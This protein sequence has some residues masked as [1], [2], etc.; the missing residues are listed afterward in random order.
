MS[1]EPTD[2]NTVLPLP[3]VIHLLRWL[4][5]EEFVIL[6]IS[7]CYGSV[8]KWRLLWLPSAIAPPYCSWLLLQVWFIHSVLLL[9]QTFFNCILCDSVYL[10]V[11]VFIYCRYKYT[12]TLHNAVLIAY[13]N[14]KLRRISL[15]TSETDKCLKQKLHSWTRHRPIFSKTITGIF[16]LRVQLGVILGWYG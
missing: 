14:R 15:T 16:K 10:T 4:K 12:D 3:P 6:P 13:C 5:Q 9:T 7:S 11:P 8:V 1:Y 2:T